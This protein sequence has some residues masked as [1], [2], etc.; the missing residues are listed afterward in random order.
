MVNKPQLNIRRGL[1]YKMIMYVFVSI[2]I[3]FI[4]IFHYT[5]RITRDIVVR[6]LKSNAQY[7]TESTVYRIEKELSSVQRVPDNFAQIFQQNDFSESELNRLLRL[8]IEN[9]KEI[10]G[11]CLAFE[12]FYKNKSEKF[13]SLYYY[14][15]NDQIEFFN[16]GGEKYDYF[17]MDWYQ[18]PKE[19]GK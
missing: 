13:Y 19:L 8:M 14:R 17:Y 15:K 6:N 5:L 7:L 9:N 16:R 12:P 1:A 4:L 3:I 11:V 2:M 10:T 18:I